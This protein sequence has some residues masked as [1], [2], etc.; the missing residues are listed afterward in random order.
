M[1]DLAKLKIWDAFFRAVTRW[2]SS[3]DDVVRH[4]YD[5][6]VNFG[7]S[8]LDALHVAAAIS[9]GAEELVTTEKTTKPL[10]RAKDIRIRSIQAE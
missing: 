10:H 2:P 4:A 8:A 7:L 5:I 9:T 3:N 1:S 6:A